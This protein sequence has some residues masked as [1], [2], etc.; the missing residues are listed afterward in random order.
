MLKR[1]IM[2]IIDDTLSK[3]YPVDV[4]LSGDFAQPEW[5]LYGSFLIWT[6]TCSFHLLLLRHR[7]P[8]MRYGEVKGLQCSLLYPDMGAET[9]AT[10]HWHK[11]VSKICANTV[12]KSPVLGELH[13]FEN[14][15]KQVFTP[16]YDQY[17]DSNKS[18][19]KNW[20]KRTRRYALHLTSICERILKE[21]CDSQDCRLILK[22]DAKNKE[23]TF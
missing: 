5:R 6:S 15:I 9:S 13:N 4:F 16:F 23:V 21:L 8:C 20:L 10:V 19:R 17:L 1:L 11:L 3:R 14:S 12:M 7:L 22:T 2:K 18:V